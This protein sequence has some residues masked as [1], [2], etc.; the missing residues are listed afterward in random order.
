MPGERPEEEERAEAL[1]LDERFRLC[2]IFQRLG[3]DRFKIT[4]GEPFM[5][6]DAL[7][8]MERLKKGLGAASVTV[9]TNG[10]T[11]DRHAPRLAAIGVDGVNISLN[12]MSGETYRRITGSDFELRRVLDN[13]LLAKRLG[14]NIKLNMV[15][16]R[17]VNDHDMLSLLEFALE[18]DLHLRFI[19]L[20]PIGRARAYEKIGFD[21]IV[22]AVEARFGRVETHPGRLGNGPASYFAVPG[23]SARVGF[24][25]AVSERF[26]SS[27]NRIRL[28][29]GGFLKTCLHHR[30][31]ADLA[32]PMRDGA[33][34]AD[35]AER[36][37]AAVAD[38]PERHRF[39]DA[40]SGG[41]AAEEPMYRIGG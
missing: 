1:S 4:G 17:S 2:G 8:T 12:A 16:M 31:G 27:C 3:V 28:T 19:E 35:L 37:R 10:T 13:I 23:Y 41:D 38:K 7:S 18:H 20:M 34:D 11:L 30:H 15:P 14:L 36:V 33:T 32:G 25:A 26:C 29:G 24:I 22:R 39:E 5:A 6:E 9:T 40:S 21:E